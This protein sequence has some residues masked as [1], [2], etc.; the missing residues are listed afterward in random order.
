MDHRDT[1]KR[2][3]QLGDVDLIRWLTLD[4][5]DQSPEVIAIATAEALAARRSADTKT[6]RRGAL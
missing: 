1:E 4:A 3:S 2:I 5:N 6:G